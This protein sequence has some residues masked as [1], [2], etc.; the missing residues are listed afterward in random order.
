ML[1]DNILSTLS[2]A[3]SFIGGRAA[4]VSKEIDYEYGPIAQ[5]DTSKGLMAQIWRAR[6]INEQ[7][8]LSAP[9]VPEYVL[10]DLPGVTEISFTFDQNGRHLFAYVQN[11]ICKMYWYD[12]Q[13]QGYI[14]TEFGKGMIT[15]RV[16]LDDKRG[17]QS[18]IS[19]VLLFYVKDGK[20]FQRRQRDRYSKEMLLATGLTAGIRKVGMMRNYRLGIQLVQYEAPT[21]QNLS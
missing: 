13:A 1:P 16:T 9:N 3:A 6:M 7:V 8:L 21:W 11:G 12:S 17:H 2:D 19:D 20:L 14:T 5:S 15:P 10:L 4:P 18:S